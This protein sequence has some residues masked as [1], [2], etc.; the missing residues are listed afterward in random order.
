MQNKLT[1]PLFEVRLELQFLLYNIHYE[2][3]T[4]LLRL[5]SKTI[6]FKILLTYDVQCLMTIF[7][8]Y[9]LAYCN[10]FTKKYICFPAFFCI[11]VFLNHITLVAYFIAVEP[12]G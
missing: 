4:N 7:V 5:C 9:N 10:V 3:D 12:I 6:S 1:A 8:V 11:Y 2:Y